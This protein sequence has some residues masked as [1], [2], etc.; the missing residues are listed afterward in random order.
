MV[1]LYTLVYITD[2]LPMFIWNIAIVK[3][4]I[5]LEELSVL[6]C[7]NCFHLLFTVCNFMLSERLNFVSQW[8][9]YSAAYLLDS[10]KSYLTWPADQQYFKKLTDLLRN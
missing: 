2:I 5:F 6:K 10:H 7:E 8:V 9:R 1:P 3:V 4:D